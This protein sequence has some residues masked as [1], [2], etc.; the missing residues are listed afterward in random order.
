MEKGN[1]AMDKPLIAWVHPHTACVHSLTAAVPAP[2]SQATTRPVRHS[3]YFSGGV[4][5][6]KRHLWK[7]PEGLCVLVSQNRT[8]HWISEFP[9]KC[10]VNQKILLEGNQNISFHKS[11]NT[12]IYFI[13]WENS[14]YSF[15]KKTL[16]APIST[17]YCE[18]ISF[19]LNEIALRRRYSHK[20]S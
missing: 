17:R 10:S 20:K 11:P 19:C 13:C 6:G 3:K 4:W 9:Q 12:P 15:P 2:M 7:V 18:L 16:N 5:I 14:S 1:W 8:K